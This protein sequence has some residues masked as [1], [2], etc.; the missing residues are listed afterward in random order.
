[1]KP[2]VLHGEISRW[3]G[4][5]KGF[6]DVTQFSFPG[7]NHR[8]MVERG[9]RDT[10]EEEEGLRRESWRRI[11]RSRRRFR[12]CGATINGRLN[13][14]REGS[15]DS[16]PDTILFLA[17]WG[18]EKGGEVVICCNWFFRFETSLR[19]FR[20]KRSD[21]RDW[22]VATIVWSTVVWFP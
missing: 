10:E 13:R 21:F 14:P 4:R 2:I 5:V 20:F 6:W 16:R 9:G 11:V 8:L 1:M 22:T 7:C 17:G 15:I 12:R 3:C 18:K 19:D